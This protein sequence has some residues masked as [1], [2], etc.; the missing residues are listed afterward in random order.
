M[1]HQIIN[2]R[3]EPNSVNLHSFTKKVAVKQLL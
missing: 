3:E 2:N 1:I